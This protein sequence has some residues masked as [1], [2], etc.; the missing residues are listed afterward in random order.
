MRR[1]TE[2]LREHMGGQPEGRQARQNRLRT[3]RQARS[4]DLQRQLAAVGLE[5][6]L[7]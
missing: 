4:G 6:E 3:R 7:A 1:G 2:C 5:K